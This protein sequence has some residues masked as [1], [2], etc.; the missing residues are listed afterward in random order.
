MNANSRH[1]FK[2]AVLFCNLFIFGF[3]SDSKAQLN[4]QTTATLKAPGEEEKV[5]GSKFKNSVSPLITADQLKA[6][7][8][9]GDD[10]VRILEPARSN[11]GY[12]AGHIPNAQF[13]HWVTDMTDPKSVE[14]YNNLDAEQFVQLMNNLGIG[15]ESRIIIYDRLSSRLSTRLYWT[16]KYYGHE[17]VQILD[18]GQPAWNSKFEQS[19]ELVK[20]KATNYA[21]G[22]PQIEILAEMEFLKGQLDNPSTKLIDGRPPEQFRGEVAGRVF[23]TNQPHPRKGHIPKAINIF[24][25]DNFNEDGTFKSSDELRAL[26]QNAG[27]KPD[28]CVVT[29]CNEG[30]HAAP[31]WFVLTELLRYEN[32]KLYDNSMAEW[33]NSK[34]PID[35]TTGAEKNSPSKQQKDSTK[36]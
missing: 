22:E 27:I 4:Q 18:G 28:Q 5:R 6:L 1:S 19:T 34:N 2:L 8:D 3:G 21:L 9:A 14:R 36:Q 13:V 24:W 15:S 7:I 32:V 16:L 25:K 35:T 23:H 26:Y 11:E 10:S 20:F 33:A 30:L 17:K 29:Y 12:R 31:P